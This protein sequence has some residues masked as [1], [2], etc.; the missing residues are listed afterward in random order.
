M[1]YQ[2][3]LE[4]IH[5]NFWQ[6][7]KP[8]LSRTFHLL[9]KLGNPQKELKFVHVAGTNGKGSFC[10]MLSSVLIRAGYRVGTYTSP[11]I[12]RFNERMRVGG[13]DI[14]DERL[15]SLTEKI[16]PLADTMEELSATMDWIQNTIVVLDENGE[17]M[18]FNRFDLHRIE[19]K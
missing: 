12:L 11:Y 15:A 2:E 6:G 18:I 13:L 1:T 4:Y 3:A 8:G 9:E 10:S 7:S 14:P 5:S 16:R 19:N 17:N